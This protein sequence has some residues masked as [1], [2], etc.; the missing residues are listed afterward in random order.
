LIQADNDRSL[1]DDPNHYGNKRYQLPG[2]LMAILFKTVFIRMNK[3]LQMIADRQLKKYQAQGKEFDI[4]RWLK[5][6]TI[7]LGLET[8]ILTVQYKRCSI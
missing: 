8:S 4:L 3:E 6:D 2:F 1:V 5:H 7:T